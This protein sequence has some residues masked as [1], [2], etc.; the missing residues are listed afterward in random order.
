MILFQSV[1]LSIGNGG[2]S[3]LSALTQVQIPRCHFQLHGEVKDISLHQF[4]DASD[5][6]YGMCSYLRFVYEDGSV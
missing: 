4:S 5:E 1:S 6:G 2:N 3:E